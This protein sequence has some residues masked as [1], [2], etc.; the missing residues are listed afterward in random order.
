MI[1]KKLIDKIKADGYQARFDNGKSLYIGRQDKVFQT[2]RVTAKV[3]EEKQYLGYNIFAQITD[4]FANL[5]FYEKP[6]F[7]FADS[8]TQEWFDNYTNETNF[9][10]K[11]QEMAQ[12]ASFAG[13]CVFYLNVDE[14]GK[15]EIVIL[16]NNRWVPIYNEDRPDKETAIHMIEYIHKKDDVETLVYQV[17]DN[18][19]NTISILA[20]RGEEAV[21]PPEEF[22]IGYKEVDGFY[23]LQLEHR[24]FYRLTNR[25]IVGEYF[26]LSDY[27][28]SI[29]NKAEEIN[30]QIELISYVLTKTAD[31]ILLVPKK[32][33]Q[34]TIQQ[35]NQ[36]DTFANSLGLA[37]QKTE[38]LFSNL[39]ATNSSGYQGL[40]LQ[41]TIVAE[42]IVR[43][44]KIL[45]VGVE[46]GK[47]EYVSHDPHVDKMEGFIEF[48]TDLIYREAKLSPA[49]FD[50]N[51]STGDLSGV[52]LQRL[53]QETLHKTRQKT[54]LFESVLKD[55]IFNILSLA[56]LKPEVPTIEWY[57]GIIDNRIEK[58]DEAERLLTNQMITKKE[59]IKM[60]MGC[61]DEQAQAVM[62]EIE[63]G[64]TNQTTEVGTSET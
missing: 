26:G 64:N 56:G 53:I 33:I 6:K 21:T 8:K 9:F 14:E 32:L 58:I 63:E 11:L 4:T 31:P 5:M 13:D 3:N 60:V 20:F 35:I 59:A 30:H 44:S 55:L 10:D 46:D 38:G 51:F 7:N 23:T 16:S 47:P 48:L 22:L 49:L 2:N 19:T 61:T 15:P 28:I 54:I 1:T 24:P 40:T 43:K 45:P 34:S 57:D 12:I 29:T 25:K 39:P 62:Q 52:A 50:K 18:L 41:E 36:S 27:T 42:A 17:F 37:D